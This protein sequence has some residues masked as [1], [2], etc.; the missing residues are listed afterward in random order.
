MAHPCE[1]AF[2]KAAVCVEEGKS[3]RRPSRVRRG[4]F[5]FLGKC[6]G[7]TVK[8]AALDRLWSDEEF[9]TNVVISKSRRP[10]EEAMPA[11]RRIAVHPLVEIGNHRRKARAVPHANLAAFRG[12]INEVVEINLRLALAYAGKR[13]KHARS[14]LREDL[15]HH[16]VLGLMRAAEL[17]EPER[18]LQ[19]STYATPWVKQRIGRAMANTDHM[20]RKPVHI[21]QELSWS[22]PVMKRVARMTVHG[23]NELNLEIMHAPAA[24][25]PLNASIYRERKLRL[26][27]AIRNLKPRERYVLVH[28]YGLLISKRTLTLEETAA[29]YGVTRERV[30]QIQMKA[31]EKLSVLLNSRSGNYYLVPE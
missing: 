13:A 31:E 4:V 15:F 7:V 29:R 3:P 5:R 12:D 20:I 2:E 19:Y 30:R 9:F 21:V 17:F 18:G 8:K 25:E 24:E 11:L 10:F 22:D 14:L 16:G 6:S 27:R 1:G 28:R 26:L 23:F